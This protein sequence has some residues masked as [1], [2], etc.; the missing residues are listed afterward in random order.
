[1]VDLVL[2][3]ENTEGLY[4]SPRGVDLTRAMITE[5]STDVSICTRKGIERLARFGLSL[6]QKEMP[7]GNVKITCIDKSNVVNSCRLF[8]AVFREIAEQYQ[9]IDTSFA[10][11]DNFALEVL[12]NPGNYRICV[13]SNMYGDI[14]SDLFAF[15]EGGSGVGAAANLGTNKALFEPMHGPKPELA[16]KGVANPLGIHN[17]IVLILEWLGDQFKES[18]FFEVANKVRK[19]IFNTIQQDKILPVDLGGGA[20]TREFST[21]LRRQIR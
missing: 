21:A 9:G 16:G 11:I 10:Y 3:R 14:L 19:A 2:V 15:F 17:C 18:F 12:Q 13:T 8:R 4:T 6:A 5:L 20:S 7:S 1:M